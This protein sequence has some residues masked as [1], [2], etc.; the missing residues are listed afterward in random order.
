MQK[1]KGNEKIYFN[2]SKKQFAK[3][4]RTVTTLY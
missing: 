3:I 2:L 4:Q 1:K